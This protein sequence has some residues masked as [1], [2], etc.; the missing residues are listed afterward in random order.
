M[1]VDSWWNSGSI[2]VASDLRPMVRV[3]VAAGARPARTM[4]A[5]KGKPNAFIAISSLLVMRG[6]VTPKLFPGGAIP[7]GDQG[8]MR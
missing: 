3:W 4:P 7:L 8:M 1:L 5:A 2:D 6:S